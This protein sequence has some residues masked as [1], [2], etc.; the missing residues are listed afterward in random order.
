MKKLLGAFLIITMML[1]LFSTVTFAENT[2]VSTAAEEATT[3]GAIRWDAWYGHTNKGWDVVSQVERSLSPSQFH[4]RAPFFAKVTDDNKIVIP[5]YTQEIFDREMEYAKYAGISYFAYIWYDDGDENNAHNGMQKARKFHQESKYRSD[6]KMC[7]VDPPIHDNA[8]IEMSKILVSDYYMTVLDG[9]PLMYY[10]NSNDNLA[11]IVE[12]IQYYEALCDELNVKKPYA[13]IMNP[14]ASTAKSN[15]ADAVSKYAI[16]GY[17]LSYDELSKKAEERW[18]TSYTQCKSYFTQFQFVPTVTYGWHPEPRYINPVS[19]MSVDNDYWCDY[20]TDVELLNHLAYALSYTQHPSIKPY[21]EANTVIAYAWNEHDEG[22]W[23]CP[24][25][26]VDANGRQL[27]NADGTP[28]IN[29]RRINA[30]KA[31]IDF[32]KS[33]KRVN[34]TVGGVSN[35]SNISKAS[36]AIENVENV[37]NEKVFNGIGEFK[38]ATVDIGASLTMNFFVSNSLDINELSVKFT[39]SSGR[40]T[41]AKGVKE[42]DYIKFSYTGINPQCMADTITAELIYNGRVVETIEDYSVK[43]YCDNLYNKTNTELSTIQYNALKRLLAD[44]L[45]YGKTAQ[46]YKGYNVEN[47]ADNLSWVETN[48]SSFAI[49]VGTRIIS[50][51]ADVNNRVKSVGLNMANVNRIYFRLTL[52]DDVIIKLNGQ[53]IDKESLIKEDDNAYVFYSRDI[54][55]TEFDKV[56]TLEL[57]RDD[58]VISTVQYN[59]NSYIENKYSVENV[60]EIVKALSQYGLSAKNYMSALHGGDDDF[61]FGDEDTFPEVIIP[62]GDGDITF[63][64]EEIF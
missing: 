26:E 48:R 5:E 56:H 4:F 1:S 32:I 61:I 10:I 63:N 35:G 17:Q 24:T 27:Y 57:I 25:L 59:V 36:D 8:R 31:A 3:V 38:G 22:G 42:N 13:V 7:V 33:G 2:E 34:V 51:N 60:G 15:S 19:W 46:I 41:T 12:K 23:I 55:A 29:E 11:Y 58:E 20:A 21:T 44:M 28:K 39:S 14:S 6:V 52:T 47:L 62:E 54:Y 53:I 45:Y 49:P 64:D 16:D 18:D 37:I 40:I 30:T 50:G 43:K 9:R